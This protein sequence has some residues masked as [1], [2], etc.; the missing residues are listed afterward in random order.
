MWLGNA[1]H[2]HFHYSSNDYTK[3]SYVTALRLSNSSYRHAA[4]TLPSHPG[5]RTTSS[6]QQVGTAPSRDLHY[7]MQPLAAG[8]VFLPPV[9]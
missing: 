4:L 5:P 1:S 9:L 7:R 3:K 2:R 6:H 8:G